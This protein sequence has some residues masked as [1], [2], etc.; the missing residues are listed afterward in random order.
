MRVFNDLKES[1]DGDLVIQ[2][3]DL[4]D[5]ENNS[6]LCLNQIIR[7]LTNCEPGEFEYFDQFGF[8]AD[9]YE[10]QTNTSKLGSEIAQSLKTAIAEN[11]MLYYPEIEVIP[12]PISKSAIALRVRVLT[13]LGENTTMTLVYDTDENKFGV[14]RNMAPSGPE[15]LIQKPIPPVINSRM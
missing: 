8:A 4:A 14:V 13:Y 2:G 9:A 12:F 7:T 11:T 6:S 3:G 1:F 15:T 5:T 10:G